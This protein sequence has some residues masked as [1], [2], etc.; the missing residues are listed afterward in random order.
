MLTDNS[1]REEHRGE[2]VLCELINVESE[3]EYPFPKSM[4]D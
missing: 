3:I 2:A 4:L 1:T